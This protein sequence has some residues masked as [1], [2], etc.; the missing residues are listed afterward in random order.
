MVTAK[1]RESRSRKR[2]KALARVE[3]SIYSARSH[4]LLTHSLSQ[5]HYLL[6][7]RCS[8]N[9]YFMGLDVFI[10]FIPILHLSSRNPWPFSAPPSV[11]SHS[12]TISP[13]IFHL[14]LIA[15]L[16]ALLY[17]HSHLSLSLS[18]SLPLSLS[19]RETLLALM[20]MS[21]IMI[22]TMIAYKFRS[23]RELNVRIDLPIAHRIHV[24]SLSL[25]PS[26]LC[27]FSPSLSR[28]MLYLSLLSTPVSYFPSFSLH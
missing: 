13:S 28:W 22:I 4:F 25:T 1:E 16:F 3:Y 14:T 12:L 10:I 27:C 7:F 9:F 5:V 6:L 18:L 20:I 17:Y 24:L 15:A 21:V 19:S 8:S 26:S 23:S 2:F 11:F